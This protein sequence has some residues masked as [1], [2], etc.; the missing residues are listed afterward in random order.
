MTDEGNW[1][2]V[3]ILSRVASDDELAV[4]FGRSSDEVAGAAGRR[5]GRACSSAARTRPQPA[6]DGK[7][8]AAW[9]GLAIARL[10]RCGR[11]ARGVDP[12][13]PARYLAAAER[14]AE[15]IVDGPARRRTASL[16]RSWKDGRAVG[17]G[18]LEDYT[19]LAD[20]LLALY[21]A[22]FEERWFKIARP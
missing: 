22:S 8:L 21:E 19:H 10:R 15:T 17:S 5:P 3:T 20:G 11:R 18:V 1:E 7:A 6:R 16:G 2:G 13:R 12:T 14:A 9:N 4:P